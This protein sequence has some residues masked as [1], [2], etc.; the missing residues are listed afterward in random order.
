VVLWRQVLLWVYL[1]LTPRL[2]REISDDSDYPIDLGVTLLSDLTLNNPK[3]QKIAIPECRTEW[4]VFL[5]DA[6]SLEEILVYVPIDGRTYEKFETVEE[7]YVRGIRFSIELVEFQGRGRMT[8][9]KEER[10]MYK[11]LHSAV[12]DIWWSMGM[13]QWENRSVLPKIRKMFLKLLESKQ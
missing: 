1:L 10:A 13:V 5:A 2:P 8:A 7:C 11:M 3:I 6:K 9:D 4:I 12:N